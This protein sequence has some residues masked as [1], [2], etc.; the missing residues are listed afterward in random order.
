MLKLFLAAVVSLTGVRDSY[1]DLSPDGR[2][3]LFT[4]NRSGRQAVWVAAAD[5]SDPRILFDSP[6]IGDNPSSPRWSPDGK[7][8]AFAMKPS[9]ST[10][11]EESE[12]YVMSARGDDV[13]RLTN[14][15][16]DDAHP[17]WSSDGKRIFFNS[18]R[19]TP[20]LGAEW[21]RQWIDIYSMAPDGGNLARHTDCRSVCSYP[22]PSPDGTMIAYRRVI[23]GPGFNWT[24]QPI[25]RNSEVFV[26]KTDGSYAVNVSNSPHFDGWPMWSPSGSWLVFASNR[27]GVPYSAQVYRVG[28]G[29]EGLVA[30]TS[31]AY[32]RAQPSFSADGRQLFFYESAEGEGFEFGHI[33]RI[34]IDASARP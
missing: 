27:A 7:R 8:I 33:G 14:T 17:H 13:Q 5:G 24:L 29:G 1:P 25:Q 2:S 22:V 31:G 3:L 16:G 30:L 20:D 23:D 15:P 18:A 32:S 4:S 6:A 28:A 34:D 21:S 11:A 10:D 9:G 26:A 19:A 12:I